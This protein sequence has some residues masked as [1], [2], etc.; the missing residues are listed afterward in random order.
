MKH[1]LTETHEYNFGIHNIVLSP[2]TILLRQVQTFYNQ[3]VVHSPS[4][5]HRSII[6]KYNMHI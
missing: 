4:P 1:H 5:T 6:A 2:Q 3:I